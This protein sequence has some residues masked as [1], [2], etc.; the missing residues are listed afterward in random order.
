MLRTLARPSA[1]FALSL[2]LQGKLVPS[3]NAPAK[4]RQALVVKR[5]SAGFCFFIFRSSEACGFGS[6][7]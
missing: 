4:R 6:K 5:N 3:A 7:T 1:H 2:R